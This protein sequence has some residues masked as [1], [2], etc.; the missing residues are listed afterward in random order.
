MTSKSAE[1]WS[2]I[3]MIMNSL[4]TRVFCVNLHFLEGLPSLVALACLGY[5]VQDSFQESE[6]LYFVASS[7]SRDFDHLKM[8]YG[9]L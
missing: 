7:V 3:S 5:L 8:N 2:P 4:I 1:V 9:M 6:I